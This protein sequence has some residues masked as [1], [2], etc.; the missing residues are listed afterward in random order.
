MK[1]LSSQQLI[2]FLLFLPIFFLLIK[3]L[4]FW[5]SL[6]CPMSNVI[7]HLTIWYRLLI[8]W[9][10]PGDSV[11]KDPPV[12]VGDAGDTGSILGLGRS[13]EKG[14]ATHSSII[15]WNTHGQ[16]SLVSYSPCGL[17]KGRIWLSMYMQNFSF[18]T[19]CWYDFL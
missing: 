13:L 9:G 8:G 2:Y 18:L 12:N 4:K 6:L 5:L 10:F 16:R 11:V 19:L 3:V 17:K 15:A 7:C 1:G 14:M